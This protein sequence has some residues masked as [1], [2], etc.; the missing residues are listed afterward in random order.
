MNEEMLR[1]S[2][3]LLMS[4]PTKEAGEILSRLPAKQIEA[5]SLCIANL[6]MVG[7]DEQEE[8]IADFFASKASALDASSG[9]F[10][11]AK[12]LIRQALGKDAGEMIGQ[13]QQSIESTPFSFVKKLDPQTLINFIHE[14]H[15]QTIALLLSHL[16]A[17]YGAEII[18]GLPIEKQIEVI[19]RV[20]VIGQ[21][22]SDAVAE[23]EA[24]LEARLSA[25]VNH[26]QSNVGGVATV[27]GILNV[28]ERSIERSIMDSLGVEDPQLTDEIRRLMFVFEDIAKLT[29]RDIQA[30]LK[31]VDAGQWAMALKGSSEALQEK[32]LRNMSTRAAENL[33]EEMSF[34]G[35]V[36]VSEVEIVQQKIVD[37]VRHL[38]EMGELTRPTGDKEEEFVN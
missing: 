31:N 34:L 14:E 30:L 8:V 3:I 10:D 25:M 29:D 24:G 32:V 12:E 36:R 38:E 18:A 1:K 26:Q 9:G 11:R 5:I 28:S 20:S 37:I 15:A 33:R 23:L 4:L 21:T 2:A 35:S 7:G 17:N 16:P 27:A 13:L 19:R 6:E 22:N